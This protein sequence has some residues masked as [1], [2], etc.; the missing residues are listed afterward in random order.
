MC[1]AIRMVRND[2]Y[3]SVAKYVTSISQMISSVDAV[4]GGGDSTKYDK[5]HLEKVVKLKSE[6]KDTITAL[7]SGLESVLTLDE[8]SMEMSLYYRDKLFPILGE[9]REIVDSLE[10]L[11]DGNLWSIPT[12]YDLLFNL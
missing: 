8:E 1:T 6:L 12:Y 5:E 2:V 3:P 9:M 11:V 7:N 10:L 4:L